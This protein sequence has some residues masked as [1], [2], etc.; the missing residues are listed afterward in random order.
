MSNEF[1]VVVVGTGAAGLS[2]ALAADA[3][4]AL[5]QLFLDNPEGQP[6]FLVDTGMAATCKR[7]EITVAAGRVLRPWMVQPKRFRG[8]GKHRVDSGTYI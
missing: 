6:T 2:A 8:G 3:M 7:R 4:P 1:D 5:R